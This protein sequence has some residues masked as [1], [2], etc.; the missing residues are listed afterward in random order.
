[1]KDIES[2]SILVNKTRKKVKNFKEILKV[3][4]ISK[5]KKPDMVMLGGD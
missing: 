1:M 2:D 4:K 3:L 5:T